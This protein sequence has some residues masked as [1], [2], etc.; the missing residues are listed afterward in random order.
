MDSKKTN[1]VIVINSF[2]RDMSVYPDSTYFR[3]YLNAVKESVKTIRLGDCIIRNSQYNFDSYTIGGRTLTN[4]VLTW[5]EGATQVSATIPPGNYSIT[6]LLPAISSVMTA[7]TTVANV[8]TATLDALSGKMVFAATG[9]AWGFDFRAVH[10]NSAYYQIG[11]AYNTLMPQS[12][13][14]TVLARPID[15]SG[16]PYVMI[17]IGNVQ[18]NVF[19]TSNDSAA[20]MVPFNTQSENVVYYEPSNSKQTV[21]DL[22]TPGLTYLDV[23]LVDDYANPINLNNSEWCFS[24]I[25]E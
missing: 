13:L 18:S 23:A 10:T 3:I 5:Y 2:D 1:Q 16:S 15:L 11:G 9:S 12:L 20:F 19:N 17:K 7:A 24:V 4:N 22:V 8:Y 6:T 25:L 14:Q 21:Y